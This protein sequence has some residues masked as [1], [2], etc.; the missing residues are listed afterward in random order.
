[1]HVSFCLFGHFSTNFPFV[2][3]KKKVVTIVVCEVAF[4]FHFLKAFMNF[5]VLLVF[6][7]LQWLIVLLPWASVGKAVKTSMIKTQL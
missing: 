5:I 3:S 2:I 1:M 7:L 4:L 6:V